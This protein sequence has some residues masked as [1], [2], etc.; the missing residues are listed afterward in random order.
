[1]PSIAGPGAGNF[2]LLKQ[3]RE[4]LVSISFNQNTLSEKAREQIDAIREITDK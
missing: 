2:K 4:L 3:I 1:M